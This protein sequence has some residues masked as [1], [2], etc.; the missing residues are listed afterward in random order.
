MRLSRA[1]TWPQ[2]AANR[3]ALACRYWLALDY[4]WHLAWI[5]SE[6]PQ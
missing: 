4:S 1:V 2:R 3:L 6:R 5:K